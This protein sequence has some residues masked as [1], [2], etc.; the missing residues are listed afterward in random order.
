VYIGA[1]VAADGQVELIGVAADR[2]RR[3]ISREHS[4]DIT[5]FVAQAG[6]VGAGGPPRR[7]DAAITGKQIEQVGVTV[8][9]GHTVHPIPPKSCRKDRRGSLQLR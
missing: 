4:A 5:P 3:G 1:I 8:D 9:G 6:P 7:V 2:R